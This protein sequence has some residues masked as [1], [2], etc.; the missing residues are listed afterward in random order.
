MI[1]VTTCN[2]VAITIRFIGKPGGKSNL[3]RIRQR[4]KDKYL[5]PIYKAFFYQRIVD[6]S[7]REKR[8]PGKQI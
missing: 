7:I 8:L 6:H 5:I 4:E 1:N 2:P 3:G